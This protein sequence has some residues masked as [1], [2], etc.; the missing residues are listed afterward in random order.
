V[1]WSAN[2]ARDGSAGG[3]E[4]AAGS[5]T[6]S[7]VARVVGEEL[8]GRVVRW[9]RM[10]RDVGCNDSC[11]SCL[12][13]VLVGEAAVRGCCAVRCAHARHIDVSTDEDFILIA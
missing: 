10:L 5:G 1:G 13:A 9:L 7:V 3:A 2:G 6:V 4:V 11:R 8:K 12:V